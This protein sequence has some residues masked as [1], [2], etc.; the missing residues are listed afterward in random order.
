MAKMSA[1][2]NKQMYIQTAPLCSNWRSDEWKICRHCARQGL[3]P[4]P[5]LLNW[6]PPPLGLLLTARRRKNSTTRSVVMGSSLWVTLA[7]I[8]CL[9]LSGLTTKISLQLPWQR[10]QPPKQVSYEESGQTE[11]PTHP[12]IA[13]KKEVTG[14]KFSILMKA[15][16]TGAEWWWL[17]H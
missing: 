8:I 3:S 17:Q 4:G 5:L 13:R 14:G 15:Q 16:A 11:R 12:R 10:K 9:L 6:R 2:P 7:R 1:F